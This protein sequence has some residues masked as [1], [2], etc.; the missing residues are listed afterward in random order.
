MEAKTSTSEAPEDGTEYAP[1][2]SRPLPWTTLRVT[3]ARARRAKKDNAVFVS[4]SGNLADRQPVEFSFTLA[5]GNLADSELGLATMKA[6]LRAAGDVEAEPNALAL[7]VL[8]LRLR[9]LPR[10]EVM[11]ALYDR[12]G[13]FIPRLR[14]EAV[15]EL[16]I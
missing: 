9:A 15:R 16:P 4:V 5:G 11:G 1:G 8:L 10:V 13:T 6:L 14:I 3:S 2:T 12:P 7:M